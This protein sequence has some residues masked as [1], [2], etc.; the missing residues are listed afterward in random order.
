MTKLYASVVA[1]ND[2]ANDHASSACVVSKPLV[3]MDESAAA[4]FGTGS[5]YTATAQVKWRNADGISSIVCTYSDTPALHQYQVKINWNKLRDMQH[6]QCIAHQTASTALAS[7]SVVYVST[8]VRLLNK[9]ITAPSLFVDLYGVRPTEAAL[10]ARDV[11]LDL[12]GAI[13]L[14]EAPYAQS[15]LI[16][17][18][19][20]DLTKQRAVPVG[21]VATGRVHQPPSKDKATVTPWGAGVSQYYKTELPYLVEPPVINPGT[22]PPANS[23]RVHLIMNN[24]NVVA[25]PNNEPLAVADISID[26]DID[27]YSWQLS[28]D[29]LNKAS[30]DLIKPTSTG[31]KELAIT[32]NGHRF[33]FFI[34]R[35]RQQRSVTDDKLQQRYSVTGH[36]R[37]QYLGAPHAPKR[38]KSLLNTT[39]VQAA[40]AEL[41]GTGFTLDWN[42]TLLPDWNMPSAFSYQ[43]LSAMSVIKKIAAAAGGVVI[44]DISAKTIYVR[45]RF[46]LMPWDMAGAAMDATIHESQITSSS[47]ARQPAPLINAVFVSGE[48][49]GVAST[50]RRINTAGDKPGDDVINPWL[51][52]IEGNTSR[53]K[54]ELAASGDRMSHSIELPINQT[55]Q[56]GLVLPGMCVSVQHAASA[57]DYRAYVTATKISVPGRALA[58]VRQTIT[59]DEPVEWYAQ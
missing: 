13:N 31:F 8:T 27:T 12:S 21:S 7:T 22:T 26:L 9:K 49:E 3:A 14:D 58:K 59:L 17:W 23:K 1:V 51:T 30:L 16:V 37:T 10:L 33:E 6:G 44:P 53:G 41:V 32:I 50:I 45:P 47:A 15:G 18:G 11:L 39:A 28:C 46:K 36:S 55:A 52:A 34:S 29:V 35:Y 5:S 54:A 43:A 4:V 48:Q 40:T 56:P 2:S 57:D 38:T 20:T 24:V 42:T 19:G 25:L